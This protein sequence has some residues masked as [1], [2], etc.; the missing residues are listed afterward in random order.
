M[1]LAPVCN[2]CILHSLSCAITA[3][4]TLCLVQSLHSTL[5]VLCNHCI[6]H[7]LSCAITAFYTLCLVQ[8]LHSTLFV[9]CN[10][11][12]L[13][14]LSC[15]ITAFYTLCLVQSLHSTLF[16]L[17][18]HCIQS[19]HSFCLVQSLHSTLFVFAADKFIA[20]LH[21]QPYSILCA[22]S[23][24]AGSKVPPTSA[25]LPMLCWPYPGD[26]VSRF[27]G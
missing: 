8:S 4:Y 14:S 10:H 24:Q 12:I 16:V 21:F 5:F 22:S 25:T 23:S 2:H 19:L 11:C 17:C 3:F 6:L 18:N 7:S 13:H 20:T 27:M 26:N 15:A 9:L 1:S